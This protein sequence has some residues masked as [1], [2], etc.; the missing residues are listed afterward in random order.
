MKAILTRGWELSEGVLQ[1]ICALAAIEGLDKVGD[2]K[3]VGDQ[4]FVT[5]SVDL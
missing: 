1:S 5:K 3:A 2:G 4:D